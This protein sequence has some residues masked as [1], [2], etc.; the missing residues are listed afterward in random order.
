MS[1]ETILSGFDITESR[2]NESGYNYAGFT[3]ADGSWR[4]LREK[5]DG[6]EVRFAVGRTDF[7]TNFTN[8]ATLTYK[9]PDQLP[10]V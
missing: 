5:T 9:R 4:I 6:T 3:K 7:V 2:E 8:R 10:R 1:L